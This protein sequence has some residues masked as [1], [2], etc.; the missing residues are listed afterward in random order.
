MGAAGSFPEAARAEIAGRH[1][2]FA[3]WFAGHAPVAALTEAL[4]AF[5]PGFRRVGPDGQVQDL[6][7]LRTS[8]AAAHGCRPEGCTIA[9]EEIALHWSGAEAALFTYV[10][11]QAGPGAPGPRRAS[12]LMIPCAG[13]PSGAAWLFVQESWIVYGGAPGGPSRGA[14]TGARIQPGKPAAPQQGGAAALSARGPSAPGSRKGNDD[15]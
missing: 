2:F 5:A 6:A 7:A 4:T 3:E 13:A 14:M 1:A 12:A 15:E 11:R 9:A 8:L 10:E